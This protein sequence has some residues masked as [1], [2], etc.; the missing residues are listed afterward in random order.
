VKIGQLAAASGVS[1]HT[2][3]FYERRGVAGAGAR[4]AR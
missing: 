1:I 3:R 2:V 4:E